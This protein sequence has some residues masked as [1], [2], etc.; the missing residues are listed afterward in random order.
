ARLHPTISGRE[1]VPGNRF[2]KAPHADGGLEQEDSRALLRLIYLATGLT[3]GFFGILQA[4]NGN[5]L[6]AAVE[7]CACLLLLVGAVC[8]GRV[9]NPTP[10]IYLYL[11]PTYSFLIYIIVMPAAS[12]SAFVWVFMILVMTYLL[13]D[14]RADFPVTVSLAGGAVA[15][16]VRERP[17]QLEGAGLVDLGS[18]LLCGRLIMLFVH[19]YESRR[20]AAQLLL[21]QMAESDGVTGVANRSSFQRELGDCIALARRSSHA[22]VLVILDLDHFKAIN[23]RWGH[24]AGDQALRHV[25]NCLHGRLRGTDLL[26][27]LGGEEFGI[28]LRD[29]DT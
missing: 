5:T 13:L 21:R 7:A 2:K 6:L 17:E 12:V 23:D 26:A 29:T 1:A 28:L 9:R 19:V 20:A 14:R 15:A 10:W 27:R 18:A 4:L 24:D 3:I 25:C 16:D 22:L 8:L 11:L